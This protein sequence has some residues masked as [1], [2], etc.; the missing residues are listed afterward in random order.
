[1]RLRAGSAEDVEACVDVLESLPDYFTIA[2]YD[3]FATAAYDDLR[4]AFAGNRMVVAQ[5][6]RGVVG[7]VL[8]EQRYVGSAEI[9]SAAVRQSER[10]AG[11]GSALVASASWR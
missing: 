3:D 4:D 10:R 7:F 11:I 1:M 2:A 9:P 8:V 5:S 6:A